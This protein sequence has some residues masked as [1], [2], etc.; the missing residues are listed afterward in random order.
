MWDRVRASVPIFA[1]FF[2]LLPVALRH[3]PII[4]NAIDRPQTSAA[5][6]QFIFARATI[7]NNNTQ[8]LRGR[9]RPFSR[10]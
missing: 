5:H 8:K 9:A 6:L 10:S 1:P 3:V 4:V 7:L 2:S